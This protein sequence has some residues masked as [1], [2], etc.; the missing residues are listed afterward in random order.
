MHN[1]TYQPYPY[2]TGWGSIEARQPGI[3]TWI[4][5]PNKL[6]ELAIPLRSRE[7][8]VAN[9]EFPDQF[10]ERMLCAGYIGGEVTDRGETIKYTGERDACE[11]D[12]GGP[13]VRARIIDGESIFFQIGIV[14]SGIGCAQRG[15]YGFYTHLPLLVDWINTKIEENEALDL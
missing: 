5:R 12:S 3:P 14:S 15:R 4:K 9:L 13:L 1:Q 10:T 7:T 8:C 2:V 6:Q 11:G